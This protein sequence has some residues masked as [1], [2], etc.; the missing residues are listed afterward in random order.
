MNR[1]MTDPFVTHLTDKNALSCVLGPE[2]TWTWS[3]KSLPYNHLPYR[4]SDW[5]LA[6]TTGCVSCTSSW[7]VAGP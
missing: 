4:P 6:T 7:L 1:G 3:S 5:T 2:V